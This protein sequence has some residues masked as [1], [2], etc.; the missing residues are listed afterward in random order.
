[1]AKALGSSSIHSPSLDPP[2]SL[3][4]PSRSPPPPPLGQGHFP[5]LLSWIEPLTF[6]DK[7]RLH[8]KDQGRTFPD[9]ILN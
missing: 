9:I 2:S 5:T 8:S 1:M 3:P 7:S 6:P 4:S